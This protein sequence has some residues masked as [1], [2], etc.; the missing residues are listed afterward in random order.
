MTH[1]RPTLETI[2]ACSE[3]HASDDSVIRFRDIAINPLQSAVKLITNLVSRL[4]FWTVHG[5][6]HVCN[7]VNYHGRASY[8]GQDIA[9]DRGGTPIA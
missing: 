7:L 8:R 3:L 4:R 9:A 2:L 5:L 1:N 6:A